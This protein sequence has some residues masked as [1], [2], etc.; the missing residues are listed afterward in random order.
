MKR[1]R[2][3]PFTQ[4]SLNITPLMD[5]LTVL[6]FFMV[7]LFSVNHT[8]IVAPDDLR[9]P[10]S[11]SQEQVEEG[12]TVVLSRGVLI[13]DGQTL[14]TLKDGRFQSKDIAADQRTLTPLKAALDREYGKRMSIFKGVDPNFL[15]PAKIII[16]SDKRLPF[17]VMKHLL[18][19][20]AQAHYTDYQF[21]TVGNTDGT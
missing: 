19:T 18:H 8:N 20:A 17:G 16:Q 10:A 9:L 1:I 13:L 15:P 6:L 12:P 11:A 21:V 3:P 2:R 14:M 4:P 5:V 7:R